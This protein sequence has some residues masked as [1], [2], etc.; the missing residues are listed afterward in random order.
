MEEMTPGELSRAL[1]RIE[2]A[3][4]QQAA[5]LRALVEAVTRAP[6]WTA[7]NDRLAL[8]RKELERQIAEVST[9]VASIMN[10]IKWIVTGVLGAVLVAVLSLILTP[11]PF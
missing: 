6:S 1:T 10:A 4:E 3:Q 5:D 9:D 11:A 8:Q 7:V 2:R